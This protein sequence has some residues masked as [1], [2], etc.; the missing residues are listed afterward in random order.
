MFGIDVSHHQGSIDWSMVKSDKQQVS[1][2]YIKA[3]EGQTYVDPAFKMNSFYADR[4]GI[5][6]G[7]YHFATLN[8][9]DVVADA[10]HEAQFFL[11][12]VKNCGVEP[13]M[14]LVLDIESNKAEIGRHFVA[15][16]IDTFFSVLSK[17]GHP[18]S[19][20]YSYTPFLNENLPA[21]HKLGDKKLWI[22]AYTNTP[23]PRLP[24]GWVKEWLWQFTA[25][26]KVLGIKGFVDCNK[27]IEPVI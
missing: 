23:A 6:V 22:A 11:A 19:V 16:W 7:F 4:A 15:L 17:A 25:R 8:T 5:P 10:T 2:A 1:F 27:S 9:S 18:D 12:T 3:T 13:K 14:P 20:L 26:G 21:D 24:H